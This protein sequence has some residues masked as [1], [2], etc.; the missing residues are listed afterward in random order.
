M[1]TART[2]AIGGIAFT[3]L[4]GLHHLLQGAGPAGSA[5]DVV[6]A[7]DVE[8]RSALLASE[9]AVG[10]SLLAFIVFL[11]PLAT[12]IRQAG[13]ES[14]AT[15]TVVAGTTFV[16]MGFL[17]TART[18]GLYLAHLRLAHGGNCCGDCDRRRGRIHGGIARYGRA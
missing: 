17:S 2:A 13:Q 18:P 5:S 15:P 9:V 3:V 6:A 1:G 14:L 12:L 7:Y 8:H 4:F 11:A 16:A 10:L